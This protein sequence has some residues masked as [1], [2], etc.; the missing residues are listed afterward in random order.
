MAIGVTL[1]RYGVASSKYDDALHKAATAGLIQSADDNLL[2][3]SASVSAMAV[4]HTANQLALLQQRQLSF[5]K[6]IT[7]SSQI[8]PTAAKHAL[9]TNALR[10]GRALFDQAD[11]GVLPAAGTPRISAAVRVFSARL[12]QVAVPLDALTSTGR[13]EALQA[14]STAESTTSSAR[15]IV[16]ITAVVTALLTILL[17]GYVVRLID[18]LFDRIRST[19]ELLSGAAAEM[20]SSAAESAAATSEQSAAIAQ[21]AS[22]IEELDATAG[23]IADNARAGTAAVDRT[24]DTMRD[25]Q[26]QVEVISQRS[27]TLGERSQK[28]GEVLGLIT[29]IAEQTNLLALNAAIEAA[30]AG[31]AGRGF[32]VV[33]SEVRKLAER[34][35]RSIDSI[36]EIITAVQDETNATIMAT[37]RGAKQARGVGELMGSTADVLDESLR[38]TDQQKEAASQVTGAMIEIRTAAEQLAAE[39]QDRAA[40]AAEVDQ[41]A[42]SLEQVLADHGV[43]WSNGHAVRGRG[44]VNGDSR[45]GS[46]SADDGTRVPLA[47][48]RP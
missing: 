39:Q 15:T 30:R 42:S 26:E 3:A 46:G 33:A 32:A 1:W 36:R 12:N 40:A 41:L 16:L 44:S 19:A 8:A 27:L 31:D 34:S 43:S 9:V 23:V 24:G 48:A 28:I 29:E 17:L 10:A 11:R 21:V 38:A 20:R 47:T 22:T 35:L 37:E 4:G 2:D 5:S 7:R 25:M 6:N 13:T 14:Q 18:R 45:P